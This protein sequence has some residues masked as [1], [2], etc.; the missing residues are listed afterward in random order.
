MTDEPE[1]VNVHVGYDGDDFAIDGIR[2][3]QHEW[4]NT[5]DQV[6]LENRPDDS[7][8]S[9]FSIYEIQAENRIIRFAAR[10]VSPSAFSFYRFMV[11]PDNFRSLKKAMEIR[12]YLSKKD[13]S[14]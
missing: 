13:Q 14:G 5:G 4:R 11:R 7:R 9:N 10:G 8:M 2:V 6:I 3:W 12:E 1:W